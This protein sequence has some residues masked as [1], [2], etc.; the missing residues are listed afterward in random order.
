MTRDTQLQPQVVTA[1][2]WAK[3]PARSADLERA[4]PY[5]A[6]TTST[7]DVVLFDRQYK[8]LFSRASNGIVVR[9]RPDRWVH[10]IVDEVLFYRD[11]S[12]PTVLKATKIKCEGIL[13]RWAGAASTERPVA[14]ALLLNW[15]WIESRRRR[16]GAA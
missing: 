13:A 2:D 16:D 7:G 4:L 14:K 11:A 3:R 1:S 12:A 8:P 9:E 15:R 5:G 6:W 10:N